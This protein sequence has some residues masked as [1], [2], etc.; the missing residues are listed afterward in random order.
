M[1]SL[2]SSLGISST[3]PS[4]NSVTVSCT[5][6][7]VRL[8]LLLG[9]PDQGVEKS[10]APAWASLELAGEGALEVPELWP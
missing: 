8:E 1:A 5:L 10:R 2:P 7:S 3:S 9:L 6:L 4:N